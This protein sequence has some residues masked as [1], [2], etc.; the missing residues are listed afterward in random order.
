MS[1]FSSSS[2]YYST[3]PLHLILPHFRLLLFFISSSVSPTSNLSSC[4]TC[5]TSYP[6]SDSYSLIYASFSS[7]NSSNSFSSP[8]FS[9]YISFALPLLCGLLL[10]LLIISLLFLPYLTILCS[11]TSHSSPSVSFTFL[12][13]HLLLLVLR[14]LPQKKKKTPFWSLF[15][16]HCTTN[17][18]HL[19][20]TSQSHFCLY[21]VPPSFFYLTSMRDLRLSRRRFLT[22]WGRGF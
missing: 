3:S 9:S 16:V 22:H 13:L 5:P 15:A 10:P 11:I 18:I 6:S 17:M 2:S 1:S 12:V 7:Y 4:S 8:T 21:S 14:L 20:T 19:R